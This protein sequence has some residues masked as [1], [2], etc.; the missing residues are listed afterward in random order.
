MSSNA[1]DADSSARNTGKPQVR[2][3]PVEAPLEWLHQGWRTLIAAPFTSLLYGAVFALV[4]V[5]AVALTQTLPWFTI[6]FLTG[7]LLI[8]PF[9]ASGL[10]IGARQ[11]EAG[12]RIAIRKSLALIWERAT[13]LGL[14]AVFLGLIAAAWIRLSALIFAFHVDS[15]SPNANSFLGLLGGSLDF[16]VVAFFLLIGALLAFV[17]FVTSA[18]AIPMIIDR[19]AGPIDA[20]LASVRAVR[21]N[22]APMALW[23]GLIV[24]LTGLGILTWFVGMV[25]LFPLLGYATWYSYRAVLQ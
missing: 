18:V 5:G 15:F 11:H 1:I 4:C 14:F 8:G 24:A 20:V 9:L 12:E 3:V 22:W 7:L 23:A 10:Y 25:V 13:N 17:I 2:R 19:D 6:A 16:G 21:A